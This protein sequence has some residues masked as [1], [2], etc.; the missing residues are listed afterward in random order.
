MTELADA[1][2]A[3]IGHQFAR[4]DLLK[5][6]LTHRSSAGRVGSNNENLEFL[7]DSVLS[8]AISDL[9][10]ERFPE[11]SEG[12]LSK[13]RAS[14]VNAGVLAAKAVAI[15]LGGHLRLGKGEEKSGG[16]EKESIL[17]S[18]YEAILGAIFLDAGFG[19]ARAIVSVHFATDLQMGASRGDLADPKTRLQ[20]LTQRRFRSTPVYAL[21]RSTGPD[22][23]RAFESEITIEGRVYGRGEGKSKKAAEQEAAL[24]ALVELEKS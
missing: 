7:G 1:L 14:V 18:S 22:H 2:E 8:L 5:L 9:L 19:A 4:R 10:L 17:A 15:G 23:A 24:R 13:L 12:G 16:R 3:A 11:M 21:V 20:E 6:A